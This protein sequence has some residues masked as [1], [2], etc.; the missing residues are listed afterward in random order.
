VCQRLPGEETR[1]EEPGEE[2]VRA[3]M[4][5]QGKRQ[6]GEGEPS[7]SNKGMGLL[8]E[9]GNEMAEIFFLPL[10]LLPVPRT[11]VLVSSPQVRYLA[12]MYLPLDPLRYGLGAMGGTV[13][14]T[15]SSK[16]PPF[17]AMLAGALPFQGPRMASA[18]LPGHGCACFPPTE[19]CCT[20]FLGT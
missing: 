8:G 14:Q 13:C 6:D 7:G 19:L 12:A 10:P 17:L 3:V 20:Q 18:G 9:Q 15:P 4:G 11:L 1:K 2:G 5:N 16:L